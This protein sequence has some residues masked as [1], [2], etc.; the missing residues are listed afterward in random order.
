MFTSQN[1]L[2]QHVAKTAEDVRK[3]RQPVPASNPYWQMQEACS[4]QIVDAFNAY[5]QARDTMAEQMFFA[6][7]GSPV[8]QS[9][10]SVNRDEPARRLPPTSYE[11]V[12]AQEK[13]K[14]AVATKLTV[15]GFDEAV[16]RS[17]LYI[18]ASAGALDTK[19]A[20]KLDQT[21]K[22]LMHLSLAEFKALVAAQAD[23]WQTYRE[24]AIEVLPELVPVEAKK[25]EVLQAVRTILAAAGSGSTAEKE[26]L[27]R[28]AQI[29]GAG[30][31]AQVTSVTPRRSPSRASPRRDAGSPRA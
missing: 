30:A 27:G 24:K 14:Q 16:V 5:S 18:L 7:F 8:V 19:A 6:I 22:Q 10:L 11:Q 29:L 25:R 3:A 28:L 1:P 9:W 20:L 17:I 2:M 26:C 4:K 31:V 13:A 21:R 12:V 23:V 15:G